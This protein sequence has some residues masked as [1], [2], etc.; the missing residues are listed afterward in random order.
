M[1]NND[2]NQC[3]CQGKPHTL[4]CLYGHFLSYTNQADTPSLRQAYEHGYDAGERPPVAPL[5]EDENE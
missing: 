3:P 5:G 2:E 1:T 4:E